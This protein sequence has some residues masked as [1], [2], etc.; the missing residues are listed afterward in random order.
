AAATLGY[1]VFILTDAVAA[2]DLHEG[3]GALALTN[4]RS[5]GARPILIS[6]LAE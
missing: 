4:M 6:D 1:A 2:V 5:A 3:D